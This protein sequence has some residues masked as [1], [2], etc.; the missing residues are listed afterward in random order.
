MSLHPKG[1]EF[2]RFYSDIHLLIDW[3]DNGNFIRTFG[4]LRNLNFFFRPGLTWSRRTTSRLS[5]RVLPRNCIFA[6]KG[7]AIFICD[8]DYQSLLALLAVVNSAVFQLFVEIQ[9]AAADAAARSYEVGIIQRTPVPD[10]TSEYITTLATLAR[11]AWS[12][13]RNL[14][15][16][17]Q[18]SHAF[19]LPGLL[20]VG[21][22]SIAERSQSWANHVAEIEAELTQSQAKIDALAF[23]LYGIG[24]RDCATLEHTEINPE[25]T[26]ADD[27]EDNDA[28]ADPLSHTQEMIAYALGVAIGRFDVR[29][30]T[31]ARSAPPEPEPFDP[32][33]VCSHGMLVGIDD[34]PPVSP[35]ELPANYP[36]P[37]SFNSSILDDDGHP[38]DLITHLRQALEIIWG[39]R[40][41][42][43][44]QEACQILGVRTLLDYFR[45]YTP[46]KTKASFFAEHLSRYSKS[47]RQAP[48]YL[49]LSTRSGSYTLC[50]Y[51][52]R[53]TDQ[54][55]YTAIN[56]YIE[57]KL[58]RTRDR[59]TQ[60]RNKTD[61]TTRESKQL[62]TL[63]DLE[64][65]LTDLCDELLRI[66]K[67]PYQ[68]N[69]NDGVQITVAPSG[70]SSA[71]PNGKKTQRNL[72]NPRKRRL[73]LVT[74]RPQHLARSCPPEMPNRQIPRDRPQP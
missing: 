57:P 34:L 37:V 36:I 59:A 22:I 62:E 56:D 23:D 44:E 74:S 47:R 7:P 3:Q 64:S 55:L 24:G 16:V 45:N 46:T 60:L 38:N 10:L 52:H 13:K 31:G 11:R 51:Y 70:H 1:G 61:R 29:L 21:G 40:A 43:I 28:I 14:D 53:L 12:L 26:A 42:E 49:P 6:D 18:T 73:R 5:M 9:L 19:N 32:L 39:D 20:Q 4:N 25:A 48:I 72:G 71:C 15:T 54:T 69:L 65:E 68:P 35:A 33:P 8:D 58:L 50:L 17:T 66:A 27:D 30:A 63:Q 67:L 2:S 41:S